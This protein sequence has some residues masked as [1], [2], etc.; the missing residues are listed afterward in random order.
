M[1]KRKTETVINISAPAIQVLTVDFNVWYAMREKSIPA[2][3]MKEIIWADFK[4]RGLSAR[5]TVA[6]YDLALASYGIKL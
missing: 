5:E 1:A 4:G 3:H 6:A 2:H